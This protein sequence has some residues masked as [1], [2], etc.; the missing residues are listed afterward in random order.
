MLSPPTLSALLGEVWGL[1]GEVGMTN[2]PPQAWSGPGSPLSCPVGRLP[3]A[4]HDP[5]SPLCLL[6][7]SLPV[8]L[9]EDLPRGSGCP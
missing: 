6:L 1:W 9:A 5:W 2:G 4:H 7:C 8:G 3:P